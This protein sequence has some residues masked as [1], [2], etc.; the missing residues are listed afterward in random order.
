MTQRTMISTL[1][2]SLPYLHEQFGV[3]KLALFGSFAAGT[4]GKKSDVDLVVE[5]DRPIGL[6]FMRLA[7]YLEK[8]LGR[9]VDMLTRDGLKGIRAKTAAA[10]IRKGLKY[11]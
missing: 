10:N 9:K 1:N 4:A 11:V 3:R 7:G 2:S 6:E 5:F 8:L